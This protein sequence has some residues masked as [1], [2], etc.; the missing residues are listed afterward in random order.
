MQLPQGFD[1]LDRVVKEELA[2]LILETL[3]DKGEDTGNKLR[4]SVM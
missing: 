3:A 1:T 4:S 2:A